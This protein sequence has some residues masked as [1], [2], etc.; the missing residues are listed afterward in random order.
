[1]QTISKIVAAGERLDLQENNLEGELR[2]S[3]Y[4]GG[5]FYGTFLQ[6][7]ATAK[8]VVE[9]LGEKAGCDIRVGYLSDT[10]RG[11]EILCDVAHRAADTWSKQKIKGIAAG[12]GRSQ[13]DGI[14]RI[15]RDCPG[16][17]GL[18][19]HQAILLSEDASFSCVPELEIYSDDVKCAHGSAVGAIDADQ[20]FYL[21]ARGIDE[22]NAKN[23]LI[24]GFLSD[25]LTAEQVLVME[26]WVGDHV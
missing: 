22:K 15:A 1:M 8:I 11:N 3:V 24:K 18:Q 10:D 25:I 26:E 16:A 20:L 9:L 4:A 19:N 21:Q 5:V 13:F 14:I 12:H 2:V 17:D 6:M 7:G 23:L